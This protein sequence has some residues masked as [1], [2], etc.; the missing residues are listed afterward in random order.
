L[1]WLERWPVAA[2][3]L[4]A[5]SS[6]SAAEVKLSLESLAGAFAN[7]ILGSDSTAASD[8]SEAVSAIIQAI[9]GGAGSQTIEQSVS[10]SL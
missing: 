1:P 5:T 9:T 4:A 2:V 10:S 6:T 8:L 7:L 3:P